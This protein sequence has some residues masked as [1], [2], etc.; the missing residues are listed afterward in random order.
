MTY[1]WYVKGR[2]IMSNVKIKTFIAHY[3]II[4]GANDYLKY[5]YHLTFDHIKLLYF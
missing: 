5:S 2:F 4:K 3:M 1:D